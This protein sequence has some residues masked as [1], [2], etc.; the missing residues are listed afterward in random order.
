MTS[1][2]QRFSVGLTGGIGS[3]KTTVAN[4]FGELGAALVDTDAIA[5]QLTAPGGLAIAGIRDRFGADFIDGS[6]AMDRARMRSHVFGNPGERHA[7]E[8]ILHPLIRSETARA[9]EAATGDYLIFVVP[10]LVESGTWVGRTSRI[11][12]VD[13]EE[14]VQIAR[15]MQRN[16]LQRDEVEAIMAAQASRQARLAVADDV[17]ENNG[18]TAGLLPR[19]RQLHASYLELARAA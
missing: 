10:L 14:Q 2:N 11:L 18:D 1:I 9:A 19:V 12:V 6:G 5:H 15:V 16:G 8:A 4:L 3:G 7:L 17:I 13:C